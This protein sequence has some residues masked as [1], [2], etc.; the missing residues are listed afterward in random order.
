MLPG[1]CRILF[2]K[3]DHES[4]WYLSTQQPIGV[5]GTGLFGTALAERLLA[6]G[7]PVLVHNRTR[8]KAD[9]LLVRG[10][11]WSDNPLLDCQRVIFS[12]FTTEQVGQVLEQMNSGL[13]PGQILLDTSTSDPLH[14][15]AL[16]NRLAKRGIEYL[17][18]PIF[19][20]ERTDASA[21]V[22]RDS[23]RRASRLLGM[24]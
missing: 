22:D 11:H 12:L 14:T 23:R 10:A 16:G 20:F 17:E 15:A 8:S 24:R 21:K 4:G 18:A 5:I 1:N 3:L 6:D 7:Y 2:P 9:P 13:Q 19:R